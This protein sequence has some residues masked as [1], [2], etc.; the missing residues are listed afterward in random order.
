MIRLPRLRPSPRNHGDPSRGTSRRPRATTNAA[1]VTRQ[2]DC[3]G[4]LPEILRRSG[5]RR[6][7]RTSWRTGVPATTARGS[8]VLGFATAHTVATRAS[9]RL[10]R[11]G[12]TS[13]LTTTSGILRA[14]L[15]TPA[16]TLA[17][18]PTPTTT[19]GRHQ[20]NPTSA[21]NEAHTKP[22]TAPTLCIR[23]AKEHDRSRPRPLSLTTEKPCTSKARSSRPRLDP[24]RSAHDGSRREA[25]RSQR[26]PAELENLF[27]LVIE[28]LNGTASD[29]RP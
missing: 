19:R 24:I 17:N 2:P 29:Q 3:C 18:P 1:A 12:T 21:T 10:A 22:A 11:P 20:R 14:M 6:T 4:A 26:L 16:G 9:I 28:Q 13:R 15:A 7:A 27:D 25:S 5:V 8:R 23:C